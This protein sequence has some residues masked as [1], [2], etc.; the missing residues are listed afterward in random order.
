MYKKLRRITVRSQVL[1]TAGTLTLFRDGGQGWQTALAV[2]VLSLCA[3]LEVLTN[4]IVCITYLHLPLTL[5]RGKEQD[6]T[7]DQHTNDQSFD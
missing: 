6:S 4:F 3:F 1:V 2:P 7:R 5:E